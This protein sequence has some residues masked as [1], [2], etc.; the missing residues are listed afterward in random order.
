MPNALTVER[1]NWETGATERAPINE[2]VL[3]DLLDYLFKD[4]PSGAKPWLDDPWRFDQKLSDFR[5]KLLFADAAPKPRRTWQ[6]EALLMRQGPNPMPW[7]D[8]AAAVGKHRLA[9]VGA[10]NAALKKQAVQA[11]R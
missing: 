11:A 1:H 6:E 9:V 5:R 2:A 7:N 10:V 4:R 3:P 8:V